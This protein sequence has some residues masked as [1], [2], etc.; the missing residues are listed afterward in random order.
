MK[1]PLSLVRRF[2]DLPKQDIH[3]LRSL[4]DELGLEVEEVVE[5]NGET[6]FK[7]ETLAHRGDH[8]S[9]VGIAREISA[10]YLQPI[11]PL[12]TP[13]QWA[14]SPLFLPV[15]KNTEACEGYLLLE[16]QLPKTLS[17]PP[18]VVRCMPEWDMEK[19]PLIAILNFVTL[20]MGQP[21]HS[22]D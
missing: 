11:R 5:E 15:E 1:V 2:I 7:I 3:S 22:F 19:H 12:K 14:F 6:F 4:F 13:S 9:A 17:L 20:E 18:L 21:L 10:H 8:L 16:V